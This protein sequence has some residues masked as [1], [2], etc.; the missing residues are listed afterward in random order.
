MI[1]ELAMM[2]TAHCDQVS[3]MHD[4]CTVAV[5]DTP[6]LVS[7]CLRVQQEIS[8]IEK[9]FEP[10]NKGFGTNSI[11]QR[12]GWTPLID[13]AGGHPGGASRVILPSDVRRGR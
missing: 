13:R 4:K 3:G 9:D 8:Y 12:A 5:G 2:Q 1:R 10:R 7:G 11:N 6:V